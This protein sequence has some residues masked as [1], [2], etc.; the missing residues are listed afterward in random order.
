MK[1]RIMQIAALVTTVA[2]APVFAQGTVN[3]QLGATVQ[4]APPAAIAEVQP[5]SPGPGFSWVAGYWSWN[6]SRYVWTSGHYEQTPASAQRWE[7]P[8]WERVGNGHR[9]RPGGWR[10]ANNVA[11]PTPAQTA[12]TVNLQI[13]SQIAGTS[14]LA[15]ATPVTT[16]TVAPP[17]NVQEAQPPSPGPRYVWVA[18]FWNWNGTQYAW[19]PGRWELPP[20]QSDG[21][22]PPQWERDGSNYRYRPGRWRGRGNAVVQPLPSVQVVTVAQPT[23]TPVTNVTAATAPPAPIT[24]TQPPSPGANYLWVAGYWSWNGSQYA[25]TA[26][27]WEQKPAQA[28]AWEPPQ[29]QREGRGWR[30]RAGRWRGQNNATVQAT[31]VVQAVPVVATTVAPTAVVTTA[32]PAVVQEA[33]PP[34]PGPGYTWVAGFWTYNGTQYTWTAGHWEQPPVADAQWTEPQWARDGGGYRF[35]PGRWRRRNEATQ[36]SA[37]QPVTLPPPSG[38]IETSQRP[39][40]RGR[41]ERPGR[42]PQRGMLWIAGYWN[43][44]GSQYEWVAG[45][46]EAP[47]RPRAVW[48]APQWRPGGAGWRFSPGRWR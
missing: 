45:R 17:T 31:Q 24:E 16:A 37:P 26:G 36:A 32:P 15:I 25:W 9:F 6:G 19:V 34:S 48:V 5:P 42:S 47:P 30:F 38:P 39:P 46:W 22:D 3:V 14:A 7:P 43:W 18:G 28:D 35:T 8:Q 4:T 11:V 41:A 10:G 27:R 20:E 29:W 44:N 1:R 23:A 40:A 12:Q 33:Q 13:P 21:W 2:S